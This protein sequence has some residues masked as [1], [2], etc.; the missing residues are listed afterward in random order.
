MFVGERPPLQLESMNMESGKLECS[1]QS[2]AF[3][4]EPKPGLVSSVRSSSVD[5]GLLHTQQQQPLFQIFQI[6]YK[7]FV[8]RHATRKLQVSPGK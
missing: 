4:L 1:N 3:M 5:H 6:A 7:K 2:V 8:G